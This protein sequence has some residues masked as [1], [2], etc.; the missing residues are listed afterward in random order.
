MWAD[1]NG[2]GIYDP[3]GRVGDKEISH[4]ILCDITEQT[5]PTDPEVPVDPTNPSTPTDPT[6]TEQP[7]TLPQTGASL[8]L[9]GAAAAL[10][11]A[12]IS[13]VAVNRKR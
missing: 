6:D 12:G 7:E 9:L 11:T 3:G 2:N 13:M 8:G 1:T 5:D 4:I 10:L